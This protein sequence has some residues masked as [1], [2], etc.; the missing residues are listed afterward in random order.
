MRPLAR[1]APNAVRAVR[2]L[3]DAFFHRPAAQVAR[4]L[5]GRRLESRIG[6][7][8]TGGRIIE[9][10]AYLGITDPA[11]HAFGG[12]RYAGNASLYG[13]PG[14]WYVYRS[15]GIHWC[16]NLVTA[17]VGSGAAVLIRA[18]QPEGNL[19]ALRLR[20]GGRLDAV[21]A[22]GPGKLAQALGVT[23]TLD[24]QPMAGSALVVLEGDPVADEAVE[25]TPRIGITKGVE[26]RLRFVVNL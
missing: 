22:N 6:G 11:S 23:D 8:V 20:R 15:Y 14:R 3:P 1:C 16:I 10:E 7:V 25:A 4:D 12:R 17:P 9:T 13:P 18:I 19:A 21:L 5:L 26:A 2:P 24:G